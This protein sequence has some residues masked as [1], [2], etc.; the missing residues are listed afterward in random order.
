M[1]WFLALAVLVAVVIVVVLMGATGKVLMRSRADGVHPDLRA[2]LDAW[3][4]QGA[5]V[6]VVAPDG[7]LRTDPALQAGFA[8]GGMSG[9]STLATT[10][11]GR[12]VGLDVW[13]V[14]FLPH[15]PVGSG[16]TASR[17]SSWAELPES[18]KAEFLAFGEFSEARGF[19]WGGRWRSAKFPNGDQ[20]HVEL[21]NWTR[22]P[23]PVPG[24]RYP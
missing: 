22:F 6:V 4:S 3:D 9:A 19:K 5:H 23:Y 7:G 24:G 17:W 15:V 18:V 13:P 14:S 20:P 10:P 11:H 2:L 1:A 16:G 8:A 12:G 21:P